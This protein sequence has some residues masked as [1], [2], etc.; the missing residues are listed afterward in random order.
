MLVLARWENEVIR[1]GHDIRIVVTRAESG[2]AWLG[3]DA[4]KE[5]PVHREEVYNRIHNGTAEAGEQGG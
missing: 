2:R 1:I 4:P 3:I 5:I